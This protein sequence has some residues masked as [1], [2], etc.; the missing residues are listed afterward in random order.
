MEKKEFSKDN[1]LALKGIAIIMMMFHHCFRV[2]GLFKGYNV[3]FFPL[4]QEFVIQMSSTFKICVSFFVFITGYGLFLS[5][6]KLNEKYDWTKKEIFK[7]TIGRL[8]KLLSGFWII[9]IFSYIFCQIMDGRTGQIFFK[10]GVLSGITNILI[11]FL[12]LSNLFGTN[13]FNSAWWYM[14]VAMLFVL[15]IP[16]LVKLFNKYG[17]FAVF[18]AV[19]TIPR[20]LGWKYVNSSF[21]SFLF[22][23]CLGCLFAEK[24]LMVKIA[25]LKICKNKYVSKS[26]KFVVETALTIVLYLLYNKLNADL[27]WEIRYGLIPVCLMIYLYEFYIDLPLLKQVLKFLGKYS[28]NIFLVHEFI[29]TY[30]FTNWLYSFKNFTKIAIVLLLCSLAISICI[31]LFKKIIKFSEIVDLVQRRAIK[32]I[33]E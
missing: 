30:Y 13:S 33:K 17:Y 20:I 22:P 24:N 21:I 31:E 25:N 7:W 4:N 27:F 8:I 14:T 12:G 6:R 9:A 5:L 26:L 16:V 1:T 28:M 3:S 19:I 15:V 18:A 10:N 32:L 11:N 29:R 2:K 23:L